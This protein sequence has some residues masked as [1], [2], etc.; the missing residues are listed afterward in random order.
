MKILITTL[1]FVL[2]TSVAVAGG[3]Y[4]SEK[5]YP[6]SQFGFVGDIH[7]EDDGLHP[8]RGGNHVN[9]RRVLGAGFVSNEDVEVECFSEN[10][11]VGD[12]HM[13]GDELLPKR[14]GSHVNRKLGAGFTGEMSD[15]MDERAKLIKRLGEINARMDDM[16]NY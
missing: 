11:F 12:F 8:K 1:A 15:L 16:E 7:L 9:G 4:K 13:E 10:G 2:S 6:S 5:D 3:F 14:G